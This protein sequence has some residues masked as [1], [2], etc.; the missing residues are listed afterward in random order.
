MDLRYALRRLTASPGFTLAAVATIALGVGVNAGAFS[1][2]NGIFY[3][4]LPV[5]ASAE[6]VDIFETV[7]GLP[8]RNEKGRVNPRVTTSEY[9]AY[10]DGSRTLSGLAGYS[11]AWPAALAGDEPREIVGRYVTCDYFDVLRQPPAL[12]RGL[13]PGDCARGAAPVVLLSH[14]FWTAALGADPAVVGSTLTLNRARVTV[15]GIAA[16][17]AFQP[18]LRRLDYFA[19][20]AAQPFLRP[21]R[22]W[23]VGEDFGWL[24]LIGRR[25]PMASIDDVR[26]EL[27]VIAAQIDGADPGRRT[28]VH[29]DPA[30]S[31]AGRFDAG[32]V[33]AT[34]AAALA[35]FALVLLLACA[36][37]A[38][39]FV[40]RASDR[41][42]EIAMRL[43]LGA[44][45][46][47]IV[48]Q[49]L[50]ESLLVAIT[51]GVLG[52]ALANASCEAL[53]RALI[54]SLPFGV[55]L[56]PLELDW[57]VLSFGLALAV[58]TGILAGLAPCVHAFDTRL[59]TA[60][61]ASTAGGARRGSRL[62]AALVGLQ[63]AVCI[64]LLASA[65]LLLRGLHNAHTV[66]PGFPLEDV[67]V[68][69][70]DLRDFGYV[71]DALD[72]FQRELADRVAGLPGIGAVGYAAHPPWDA[73]GPLSLRVYPPDDDGGVARLLAYA[74]VQPAYF[75][76]SGIRIVR[77]RTFTEAELV[78]EP[79]A[80]IVTETTAANLWPAR[81]PIGQT[82]VVP[83]A[84][85]R[86][87]RTL[88]V[89]GV[90]RD[91]Q[92]VSIG[93]TPPFFVYMPAQPAYRHMLDLVVR[94]RR[95]AGSVAAEIRGVLRTLDP[96]VSMSIAP[97]E[98]NLDARLEL[99]ALASGLASSLGAL[100]VALASV[101]IFAV[102]SYVVSRRMR[103]IGIR[104]ALGARSRDVFRAIL[105][106]T[107]RPVAAGAAIGAGAAAAG[108]GLLSSMLFGVSP[109]DPIGIGAAALLV[110]GVA[111]AASFVPV[112]RGLRLDPM[113]TLR[114]E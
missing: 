8:G 88:T 98:A 56:P 114:E 75:A 26:A 48:R 11:V 87:R 21:D 69:S 80:V 82:L 23:L 54:R 52:I 103:E 50:I 94:T 12:G 2:L 60:A 85:D 100:A 36:N 107:M 19:P 89:V 53:A 110:V 28:T 62:Q 32:E 31:P 17:D 10:R 76:A 68:V 49:L 113:Q 40:A 91:A 47:R 78:D 43:S 14:D 9:Q 99:S 71:D 106:R 39:L 25:D 59:H 61:R 20:I 51:G 65:G 5:P 30:W 109:V 37:V 73:R 18:D 93:E 57:R 66:D 83:A 72:A 77:G 84:G 24:S 1:I 81:D 27:G 67:A 35:P 95:D 55:V 44:S 34:V 33:A 70:G 104:L 41:A 90:A 46:A 22:Q 42:S 64:V 111:L 29:V 112:R 15:A 92:T 108:S 63:V 6:L 96:R 4:G 105:S 13:T 79:T 7:D 16:K 3:R 101:G 74:M 38:N 102:V 86:P 45:R 97:L 58:A